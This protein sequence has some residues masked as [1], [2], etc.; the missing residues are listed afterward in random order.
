MFSLSANVYHPLSWS[1]HPLKW[2]L[3]SLFWNLLCCPCLENTYQFVASAH[4]FFPICAKGTG[5]LRFCNACVNCVAASQI[6]S[7][8]KL[9]DI[10]PL[11][12]KN[13]TLGGVLTDLVLLISTL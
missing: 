10:P 13:F 8:D 2:L 6:L 9:V 5:G 4:I 11:A 1:N 3:V 12:G 7:V